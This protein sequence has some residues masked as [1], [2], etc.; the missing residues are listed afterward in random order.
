MGFA[1]QK[2]LQDI[3]NELLF[4][5]FELKFVIIYAI[6]TRLGSLRIPNISE[7]AVFRGSG[8]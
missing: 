3:T 4:D 7:N 6:F 8:F 1:T 5:N 2:S